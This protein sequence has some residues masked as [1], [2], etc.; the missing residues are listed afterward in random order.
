MSSYTVHILHDDTDPDSIAARDI[1]YKQFCTQ[2]DCIECPDGDFSCD[3]S[4][5][6]ALTTR[7]HHQYRLPINLVAMGLSWFM[8]FRT[9]RVNSADLDLDIAIHPDT[10]LGNEDD[11]INYKVWAGRNHPVN[12]NKIY[13]ENPNKNFEMKENIKDDDIWAFSCSSDATGEVA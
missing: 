10:D 7:D 13:S 12:T 6:V 1:V 5:G 3:L 11:Y 9:A 4:P 2:F 8:Q